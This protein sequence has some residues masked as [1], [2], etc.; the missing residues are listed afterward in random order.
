MRFLG[1]KVLLLKKIEEVI[2]ENIQ[3]AESFCDIFAGTASVSRY[4]K[5]RYRIISND[6]LHF[7]YVLQRATLANNKKPLFE[8][9]LHRFK[10][11]PFSYFASVSPVKEQLSQPPFI[12]EN[13]SPNEIFS[14]QYFT[15]ENAL[16]IDFVRQ[17]IEEWKSQRFL[18]SDE[19]FYLLAGLLEA[20]PFVSN[21]AGTY[22]AF[23]K[24]WDARAFKNL[25]LVRL[26]IE[27]NQRLNQCFNED[28]NKLIRSI[29]GDILYIDPP[30]NHRQYAPNYHVLETIS[31]YDN[32]DVSGKT[33]LRPYKDLHSKYCL[34]NKVLSEFDDLITNAD[35]KNI[36]VSY[37]SEGIMSVPEIEG[38]L[39][40]SGLPDSYKLY[41]I[42]Y[43]RY[44]HIPGMVHHNLEELIFFIK[45][46]A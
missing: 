5:P 19:Y 24:H 14:R 12:Y 37:S 6:I 41:R 25:E 35:F 30:Y 34:K 21:I 28:S 33:G 20:V 39:L 26:E 11:D 40:K 46:G 4:F 7:S 17:T 36:I 45:K 13:Y 9:M 2:K 42:P 44:K 32:P 27:D 8:N 23:L 16:K 38:V 1:S 10:Q 43:R 29:S 3:K 15:N 22:G 31:R 18:S